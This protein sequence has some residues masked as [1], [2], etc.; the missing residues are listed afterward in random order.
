MKSASMLVN[1]KEYMKGYNMGRS[2]FIENQPYSN[3]FSIGTD[4]FTGYS[5]GW[6]DAKAKQEQ[7]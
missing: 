1:P 6:N 3:P 4:A 5:D 7:I 2:V